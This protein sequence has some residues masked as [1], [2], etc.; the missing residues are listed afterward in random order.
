MTTV[1]RC[2]AAFAA[3]A[4][5]CGAYAP[6]AVAGGDVPAPA[7]T[8]PAPPPSPA[9]PAGPVVIPPGLYGDQDPT[10]DGVRR[11]ALAM[12]GQLVAGVRPADDAV[13]WL[14]GQQCADGAFTA[15]RPDPA[16]PCDGRTPGDV[17]VTATAV[18]TLSSLGGQGV[19]MGGAI[20]WL[21]TAQNADGGWGRA[22]GAPSDARSISLVIGALTAA[23]VR[24]SSVRTHDNAPHPEGRNAYDALVRLS[25]PCG[26][27]SGA[28]AGAFADHPDG[29]GRLTADDGATAAAVLGGTGKRLVTGPVA[30]GSTAPSCVDSGP[31]ATDPTADLPPERAARNGAAYLAVSLAATG[32]LDRPPAPGA[33]SAPDVGTTAQAVIALTATGYGDRAARA[34]EWLKRNSAAWAR[35]NGPAA[36]AQLILTAHATGTDPRDFGGIDLVRR[37]N[38]TGPPPRSI[39]PP[40]APAAPGTTGAAAATSRYAEWPGLGWI[41][42]SGL[43][44]GAGTVFL[45]RNRRK[46]RPPG[47]S[48]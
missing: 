30:A 9:P 46:T 47:E 3:S 10:R 44:V 33:E 22:P 40:P 21:R 26:A 37:L 34:L 35:E 28:D 48:A 6:A 42:G 32:H 11:Q 39:A 24:P 5:L 19:A 15:Y 45:L 41:I 8:S 14:Q 17:G 16:V 27:P 20:G 7:R 38:A 18:Q 31:T 2:A 1:R 25:V 29:S 4:V 43:A 36:W 12:L 13:R 23:G